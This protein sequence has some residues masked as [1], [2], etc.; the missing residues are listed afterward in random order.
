M[1]RIFYTLHTRGSLENIHNKRIKFCR[2]NKDVLL[3]PNVPVSLRY[4]TMNT[5]K[6]LLYIVLSSTS[7]FCCQHYEWNP[8]GRAHLALL[9][10][11]RGGSKGIPL[12][13][14]AEIGGIPLVRN[15]IR[16]IRTVK[17]VDSIWVST[18]HWKI[19]REAQKG[20][21]RDKINV[22][23]RSPES[24]TDTASSLEGIEEF[25]ENHQEVEILGLLQCT[26]PFISSEYVQFAVDSMRSGYECVFSVTRSHKLRWRELDYKLVPVNFEASRRPRRQDWNGDLVENGMFY[27]ATRRLIGKGLLQSDK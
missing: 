21:P 5:H 16:E 9:I 14:V 12:K 18:D 26:S 1:I 4:R 24:A 22:H 15:T 10:L 6:Y 27:F 8:F 25:L 7:V 13:N 19:A 17:G 3:D 23:W 20:S 2:V 11:A